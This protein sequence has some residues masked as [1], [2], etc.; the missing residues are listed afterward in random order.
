MYAVI[1][2]GGK[3]YRVQPGETIKVEKIDAAAGNTVEFSEVLMVA[4]GENVRIG[5][6]LLEGVKVAAEVVKQDRD[7]KIL[8]YKYRRRNAWHKKQGHRQPF[9]AIKVTEIRG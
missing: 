1:Q 9:T 7:E 3:Q 8:V 5:T 6:P 2:T 4:D